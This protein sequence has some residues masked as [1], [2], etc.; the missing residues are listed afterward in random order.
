M[1]SGD[2]N[3]YS[4]VTNLEDVC[5]CNGYKLCLKKKKC[6][7]QF[8]KFKKKKKQFTKSLINLTLDFV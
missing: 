7:I 8:V 5:I 3:F 1:C 2:L 4:K 6:F